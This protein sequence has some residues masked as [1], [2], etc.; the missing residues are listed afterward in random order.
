MDIHQIS[1]SNTLENDRCM[2]R[3]RKLEIREFVLW[4]LVKTSMMM[5]DGSIVKLM[6]NKENVLTLFRYSRL[7]VEELIDLD[8]FE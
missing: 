4:I 1:K 2:Q 6:M 5:H 7:S 3:R 8:V